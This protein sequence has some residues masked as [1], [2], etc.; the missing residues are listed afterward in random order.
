MK[1]FLFLLLIT[2]PLAAAFPVDFSVTTGYVWKNDH[3][4]SRSYGS[5]V[6]DQVTLDLC[7]WFWCTYGIGL[8]GSLWETDG[9]IEGCDRASRF[10]EI[11]IILYL[12]ARRGQRLQAFWSLGGGVIAAH[13]RSCR[14]KF[15]HLVP[16]GEGEVGLSYHV[17]PC[18]FTTIAARYIYS[19][20]VLS[21]TD[22]HRDY[23]GFG[24]RGGVGV[25]F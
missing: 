11:P 14:G 7:Y 3:D 22:H 20:Q 4:F 15:T 23:G 19:R 18:F 12:R 10:E 21:G 24:I 1:H 9:H 17:R 5:G 8:K 16:A 6:R 25:T 13:E 2:S